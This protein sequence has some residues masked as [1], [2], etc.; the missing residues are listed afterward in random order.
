VEC[1]SLQA[2]QYI[3][4]QGEVDCHFVYVRP[5]TVQDIEIRMI[6]NRFGSETKQSLAQKIVEARREIEKVIAGAYN[7]LFDAVIINDSRD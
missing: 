5:P 3:K 1:H 4:T 6:R 7:D 2:A